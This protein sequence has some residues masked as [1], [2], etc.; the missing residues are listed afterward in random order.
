MSIKPDIVLHHAPCA[1]GF[2]SAWV[3]RRA[4]DDGSI[5][6]HGAVH[7]EPPPDVTGLHVLMLD[8]SY[9]RDV[10]VEMAK[11]A[12]TITILDHHKSAQKDLADFIRP[13]VDPEEFLQHVQFEAVYPIQASF[14]MERSG[15]MMTWDYLHGHTTTAPPSLVQYV[16]DRDLWRY[17]LPLSREVNAVVFSYDYIWGNWDLLAQR[18]NL[19]F[20]LVAAEGRAILRKQDKDILELVAATRRPMKI[21]GQIVQVVNLPYTIVSEAAG[22]LAAED[23]APFAAG[24]FDRSDG[25][26]VF[27][28]RSSPGRADVSEIARAYGGGGHANAAGFQRPIGWEGDDS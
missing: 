9:K 13:L 22:H 4:F 5:R 16:Q 6:F 19:E 27:S 26:R 2:T 23:G 7:G 17:R 25:Q 3:V 14:D 20:N 10:L 1:D 24:Y 11:T 15:A 12:K 8:F 21:A 28:L 18:L